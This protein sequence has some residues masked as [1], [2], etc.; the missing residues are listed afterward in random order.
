MLAELRRYKTGTSPPVDGL[1]SGHVP[2]NFEDLKA[3]SM[4]SDAQAVNHDDKVE[5]FR[6]NFRRDHIGPHY[7]GRLH[8][9]FTIMVSLCVIGWSIALLDNVTAAEWLIVPLTFLYANAV[10]Y[11]GHRGPMHHPTRGLRIIFTRHTLEHHRFFTD[12][13]MQF[14]SSR[15]YKAVLFPPLLIVFFLGLFALPMGLLIN[16]LATP[17]TALLFIATAI[18]YF[19]NYELL[20]FAYHT[21]QDSWTARIPFMSKLRRLHTLHHRQSLMQRYNFNITYPICDRI[22]GTLYKGNVG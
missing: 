9:A 14:G 6:H 11:L 13:Q 3:I 4:T 20:H 16:F 18:A 21:S 15:D 7:S 19:L 12:A 8:F 1:L 2:A 22:F 17:N 10:E 5:D